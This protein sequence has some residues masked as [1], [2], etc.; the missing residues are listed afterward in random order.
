MRWYVGC[1]GRAACS[2]PGGRSL[3]RSRLTNTA[4]VLGVQNDE[5]VEGVAGMTLRYLVEGG[6]AYTAAGGSVD[7]NK[8]VA[9]DMELRMAGADLVEGATLDRT[10][11]HVITLRDRKSTRLNSSH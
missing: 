10:L 8:V 4:G 3:Y 9:V 1:N 11:R 2:E 6:S 5:I 7:W